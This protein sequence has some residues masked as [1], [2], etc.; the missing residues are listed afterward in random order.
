M[1]T[2]E[3]LRKIASKNRNAN[4]TAKVEKLIDHLTPI[5]DKAAEAG[6]CSARVPIH[7][8][9]PIYAIQNG[10]DK[11][12]QLIKAQLFSTL[13]NKYQLEA[14]VERGCDAPD[15]LVIHIF[16]KE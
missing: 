11:N 15:I 5:V 1:K 12:S 2:A 13:R 16:N 3:E 4:I 8:D 7:S 10:F 9:A 6:L 14:E